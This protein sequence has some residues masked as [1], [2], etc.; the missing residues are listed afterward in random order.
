MRIG[1]LISALGIILLVPIPASAATDPPGNERPRM[2][3]SATA[4]CQHGTTRSGVPTSPGVIA[5]DPQV[6]PIGSVIRV[7]TR[8]ST[9]DGVYVVLDTGGKVKGRIV[10]IYMRSCREA[11][12]FGR[13]RV[14]I[15]VLQRGPVEQL[16]GN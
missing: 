5:A 6:L 13:Q 12:I 15:H 9:Y 8:Q 2:Q 7:Q 10:D 16:A 14:V 4:Y 11:K 3:A 1:A